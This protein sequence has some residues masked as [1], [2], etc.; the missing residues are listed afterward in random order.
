MPASDELRGY[1]R[2]AQTVMLPYTKPDSVTRSEHRAPTTI[3]YPFRA[4]LDDARDTLSRCDEECAQKVV[5]KKKAGRS[6]ERPAL[7]TWNISDSI[8]FATNGLRYDHTPVDNLAV[9]IKLI[10]EQNRKAPAH[11]P[12]S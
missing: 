4:G 3:A 5:A 8:A 9:F 1:R 2:P 12:K 10:R 6:I 7:M 11:Y